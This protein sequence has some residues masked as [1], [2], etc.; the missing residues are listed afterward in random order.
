MFEEEKKL[1]AQQHAHEEDDLTIE[2]VHALIADKEEEINQ[3]K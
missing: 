2:M 3:M 1:I